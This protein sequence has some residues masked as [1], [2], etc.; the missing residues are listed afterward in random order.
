MQ[1]QL[2]ERKQEGFLIK[3]SKSNLFI[4]HFAQDFALQQ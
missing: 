2:V 3:H 4:K 1:L